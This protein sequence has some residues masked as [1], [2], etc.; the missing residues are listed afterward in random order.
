M[1]TVEFPAAPAV[2]ERLRADDYSVALELKQFDCTR[3]FLE[4]RVYSPDCYKAAR[5]DKGPVKC[6]FAAA[7]IPAGWQLRFTVRPVN[8]WGRRGEPISSEW[9]VLRKDVK[10]S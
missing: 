9:K 8:V 4:K 7:E 1:L 2:G 3:V 10:Q 6:L 5:L